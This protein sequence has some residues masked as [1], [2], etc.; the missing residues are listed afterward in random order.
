[1]AIKILADLKRSWYKSVFPFNTI[2]GCLLY[3]GYFLLSFFIMELIWLRVL[4]ITELKAT[5][6]DFEVR[7]VTTAESNSDA[8]N[9]VISAVTPC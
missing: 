1:M 8:D 9:V 2:L 3:I 7:P 6:K 4:E 5:P